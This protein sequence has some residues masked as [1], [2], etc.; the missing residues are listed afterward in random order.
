MPLGIINQGIIF[1][2]EDPGKICEKQVGKMFFD[3]NKSRFADIVFLNKDNLFITTKHSGSKQVTVIS[4]SDGKK[5][6]INRD[7][8]V[9]PLHIHFGMYK[10][11]MGKPKIP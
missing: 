10:S 5:V 3:C 1:S 8:E 7:Q 4:F 6:K 2:I 11:E 9:Y